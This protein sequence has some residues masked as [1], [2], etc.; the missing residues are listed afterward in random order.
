MSDPWSK[1]DAVVRVAGRQSARAPSTKGGGGL[2]WSGRDY[3]GEDGGHYEL[4]LRGRI[5]LDGAGEHRC[6]L[7]VIDGTSAQLAINE[8]VDL[9][10]SGHAVAYLDLVGRIKGEFRPLDCG[11]VALSWIAPET[12]RQRL[13]DQFRLL[14]GTPSTGLREL[15]V[16]RRI[17]PNDPGVAVA[18]A[19]GSIIT[20][21]ISNYSR[22]GAALE[23]D[24]AVAIDD[25]VILGRT[26]AKVVRTFDAGFAVQFARLL[27][28]ETFDANFQL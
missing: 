5:L 6:I 20:G 12:K 25:R 17:V 13:M 18:L 4:D 14:A 16:D 26:R 9:P 8:A 21:A 23:S 2:R 24:A 28:W 11:T 22:S 10:P 1:T 19:D 7:R 3:R 15:R 27:P